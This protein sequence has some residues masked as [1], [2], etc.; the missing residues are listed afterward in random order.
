MLL[1]GFPIG[2]RSKFR[3]TPPTLER[4]P[5]GPRRGSELSGAALRIGSHATQPWARPSRSVLTALAIRRCRVD[6]R[7][8]AAPSVQ[9]IA[10]TRGFLLLGQQ[11]LAGSS[12]SSRHTTCGRFIASPLWWGCRNVLSCGAA[13]RPTCATM[14][15]ARH[16]RPCGPNACPGTGGPEDMRIW[17][18]DEG[19]P[20]PRCSAIVLEERP[21]FFERQF[22]ASANVDW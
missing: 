21:R 7:Q 15:R 17:A 10:H 2:R 9:R 19:R 16:P 13:D 14:R 1:T 12:R 6:H 5:P 4:G 20:R 11:F 22:R 18:A 3:R 8:P